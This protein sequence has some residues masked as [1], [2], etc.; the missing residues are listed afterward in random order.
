MQP[1]FLFFLNCRVSLSFESKKSKESMIRR[2]KEKSLP[3]RKMTN[4]ALGGI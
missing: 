4:F 2:D 3:T 1:F